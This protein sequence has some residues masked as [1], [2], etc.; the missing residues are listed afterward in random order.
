[1]EQETIENYCKT[2]C[3]LDRGE[4]VKSIDIAKN[5]KLSKISVSLTLHKLKD[6]RYVDME[7]YGR[8]RLTEKGKEIAEK[9]NKKHKKII[10]FLIN[11][12]GLPETQARYEACAMEHHLSKK[13]IDGL[14]RIC[15]EHSRCCK[16]KKKD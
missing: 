4:G 14:S 5:L 13:T 7:K 3:A 15:K 11:C 2:I 8:V 12:I 6:E 1:M 9:I 16:D 10:D